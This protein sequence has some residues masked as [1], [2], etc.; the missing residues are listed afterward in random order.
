M[1]T[2]NA[3]IKILVTYYGDHT[4]QVNPLFLHGSETWRLG[5][6]YKL[7]EQYVIRK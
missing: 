5:K 4:V 1:H 2:K 3:L 6:K 7:S